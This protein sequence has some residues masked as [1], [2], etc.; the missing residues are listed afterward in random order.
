MSK[1]EWT[2]CT[3]R[4]HDVIVGSSNRSLDDFGWSAD[5]EP[6]PLAFAGAIRSTILHRACYDF[7]KSPDEQA[8][9]ELET[10]GKALGVTRNN[11]NAAPDVEKFC[12]Y[13]P[14]YFCDQPPKIQKGKE[15][16]RLDLIFKAPRSL[17]V[18]KNNL[19]A[20]PQINREYLKPQS[21]DH[22]FDSALP[23]DIQLA[24]SC[25]TAAQYVDHYG[26]LP[27]LCSWLVGKRA[28]GVQDPIYK[29]EV[30]IGHKRSDRGVPEE[31]ALFSRECRRFYDEVSKD[32][33]KKSR[34]A[35]GYAVL[36]KVMPEWLPEGDYVVRIGSDGHQAT[37][38]VADASHI[39]K[40][41]KKQ[42]N[43]VLKAIEDGKHVL[44]YVGT[45]AIFSSGWHP[46]FDASSGLK[47]VSAA[48]GL[49]DVVAG[50]DIA[51]RQ[52]RPPRRCVTAGAVYFLQ[53]TDRIK[54]ME[55]VS[56]HGFGIESSPLTDE[57]ATL[58]F[59]L[60]VFGIWDTDE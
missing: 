41:L 51:R 54:A 15:V 49:P 32:V 12:A 9:A 28:L 37:M 33:P 19:E 22:L 35:S 1:S 4:P 39:V 60:T 56:R 31:A 55:F 26:R 27:D 11:P 6:S 24:K 59:G 44:L 13:G 58:G 5:S 40:G 10:L 14:L 17:V 8:S 29:T 48:V 7:R 21:S 47:M 3:F 57:Y 42:T 50:W 46:N 2:I 52:P 36:L 18:D 30:Q 38:R 20:N 45:P 34:L 53:V 43:R 25:D 16:P 23:S